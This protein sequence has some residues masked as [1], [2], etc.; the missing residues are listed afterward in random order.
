M[1]VAVCDRS[2]REL[3]GTVSLSERNRG[4]PLASF[5]AGNNDRGAR[6]DKPH[7]TVTESRW[8]IASSRVEPQN[9]KR[10]HFRHIRG[11]SQSGAVG[12]RGGQGRAPRRRRPPA[13]MRRC[14]SGAAHAGSGAPHRCREVPPAALLLHNEIPTGPPGDTCLVFSG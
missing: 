11:L 2:L 14:S 7:C 13:S 8:I 5:W 3:S 1:K 10:A 4:G 6:S 9:K 12:W